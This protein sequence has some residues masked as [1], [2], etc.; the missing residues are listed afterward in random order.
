[1]TEH[2][3]M[4]TLYLIENDDGQVRV[5]SDY[6][7]DGDRCLALGVEIMQSLATIQPFTGGDLTLAMPARTD[8]EH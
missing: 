3:K 5:I 8:V 2:R 1:M 6:S 7:G 4:F